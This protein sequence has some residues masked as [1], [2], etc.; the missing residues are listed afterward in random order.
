MRQHRG[1]A[2]NQRSNCPGNLTKAQTWRH[3][4]M[5]L[6]FKPFR[7]FERVFANLVLNWLGNV[8]RVADG[9]S[10]QVRE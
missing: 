4:D 10:E 1:H 9:F 6:K 3:G 5:A 8:S 2:G 7:D